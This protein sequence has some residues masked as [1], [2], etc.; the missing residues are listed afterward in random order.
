[1]HFLCLDTTETALPAECAAT[2]VLRPGGGT[3]ATV[4][5]GDE[6]GTGTVDDVLVDGLDTAATDRLA[7]ALTAVELLGRGDG[8]STC[9]RRSGSATCS[10]TGRSRPAT[11]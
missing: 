10:A 4:R 5:R 9:P 7:R 8:A 2:V 1:M 3:R 6:D 11:S